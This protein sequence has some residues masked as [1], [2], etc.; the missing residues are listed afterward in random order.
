MFKE[1]LKNYE[2]MTTFLV[3]WNILYH[4]KGGLNLFQA[5]R[6]D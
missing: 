6:I 1:I 5:S 4:K 3:I 2:N